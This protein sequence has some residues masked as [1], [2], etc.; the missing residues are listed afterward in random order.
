MW[1]WGHVHTK[2]WQPPYPYSDLLGKVGTSIM[3]SL[4]G[5]SRQ[6]VFL[7][8]LREIEMYKLDFV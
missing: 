1:T 8:W 4:Q 7:N 5:Q 2:F 6:T 3:Y